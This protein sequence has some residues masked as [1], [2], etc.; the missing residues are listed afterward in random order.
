MNGQHATNSKQ[1]NSLNGNTNSVSGDQINNRV[2]TTDERQID[3][4]MTSDSVKEI[5][6]VWS[7]RNNLSS[8]DS[9][10][11]KKMIKN[12]ESLKRPNLIA[13]QKNNSSLNPS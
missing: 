4:T 7:Q 2:L 6:L 13:N 11:D 8:L 1:L 3:L 12:Y 9:Q 5:D 10:A